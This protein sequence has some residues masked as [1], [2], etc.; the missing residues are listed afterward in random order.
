MAAGRLGLGDPEDRVLV[1]VERHR[2]PVLAKV[3]LQRFEV[4]EGALG[5]HEAHLHEPARGIVDED[6]ERAGGC[7]VLEPA[8]LG[9]V[10]L[11]ELAQAL[12]AQAG[13]MELAHLPARQPQASLDH[14]RPQRLARDLQAVALG[15]R[16]GRQR[17]V[18]LGLRHL[19][20][21]PEVALQ[22]AVDR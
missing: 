7:P 3:A 14:P 19:G 13:L 1:R 17:P 6:E 4:G 8:V 20:V 18:A 11:H 9:A 15:Q 16:L 12:A 22:L 10:D 2:A 5:G 21:V